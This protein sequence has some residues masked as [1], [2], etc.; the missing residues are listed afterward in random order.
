MTAGVVMLAL[1]LAAVGTAEA[2]AYVWRYGAAVRGSPISQAGSTM[3]VACL[4]VIFTAA[5]V[6]AVMRSVP[7][8]VV[9]LAYAVP[10]GVVTWWLAIRGERQ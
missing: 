5:G 9:L 10:A 2:M 4:R 6:A 8:P 1:V 3:V 7:L